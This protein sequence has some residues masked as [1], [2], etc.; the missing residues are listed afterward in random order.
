M[1]IKK[2][3][4]KKK[5]NEIGNKNNIVHLTVCPEEFN[6]KV[7]EDSKYF[8]ELQGDVWVGGNLNGTWM[9]QY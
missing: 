2:E 8:Y 4:K 5:K 7:Q 3:K 9:V 6:Q 1:L